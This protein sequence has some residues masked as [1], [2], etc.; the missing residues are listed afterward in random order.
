MKNAKCT[1]TVK[2]YLLDTK[3]CMQMCVPYLFILL[4]QIQITCCKAALVPPV[5]LLLAAGGSGPV[6]PGK[7]GASGPGGTLTLF[8]FFL[9]FLS[10]IRK[11]GQAGGRLASFPEH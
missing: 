10:Q 7:E 4:W 3:M 9:L 11:R 1:E 8:L 6:C 2:L 5:V